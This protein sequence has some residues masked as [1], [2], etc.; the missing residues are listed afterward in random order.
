MGTL[1]V[2]ATPIGNLE[3]ITLR[4]LRVLDQVALIAAE[5]TR[6]TRKLLTRH[7]IRTPVTAYHDHTS[8]AKIGELLKSLETSD[9]ALVSEA[10]MPG[11]SDPGRDLV[12]L[13]A[14]SG[15]QV[16]PVP[17]ASAPAA[18]LAVSGLPSDQCL[19]LGFLPR[20]KGDR[21][22]L[23]ESV[24][25]EPYTLVVFEAPH[26][27]LASLSDI[28]EVLGDRHLVVCREMTKIHEEVYRGS[29]SKALSHFLEPRG[30]FTV[31][32]A[33]AAPESPA[34]DIEAVRKEL[35]VLKDQ[36][37][38]ARGAV[39]AV[40]KASG[41]PKREVYKLWLEVSPGGSQP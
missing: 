30:E 1:Y 40:A 21:V 8:P 4:A 36:G 13:A 5:D 10:G 26:R 41:M 15:V 18:A 28:R 24:S 20:K 32:I 16:V 34:V 22:R 33:G 11:I 17:G 27:I 38:K 31:V 14:A 19:F 7:G 35:Q 2:V 9:M 12:G 6:T 25:D 29:V 39:A 37:T 23:L 3:D